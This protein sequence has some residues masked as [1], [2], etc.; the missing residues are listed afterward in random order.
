MLKQYEVNGFLTPKEI[1]EFVSYENFDSIADT[2]F[3]VIGENIARLLVDIFPD[4][5]KP[6]ELR[7]ISEIVNTLKQNNFDFNMKDELDRT[8]LD[9]ALEAE[10]DVIA[11]LL[12]TYQ[13]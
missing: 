13:G 11:D 3:N 6:K 9:Q 7:L 4:V 5:T 12:R 1:K 2:K 10:N 8:P